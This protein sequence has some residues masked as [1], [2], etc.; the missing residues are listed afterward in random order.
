MIKGSGFAARIAP[1]AAGLV[2]LAVVA[3]LL[4]YGNHSAYHH[5][6]T[7]WGF[8]PFRYAFVDLDVS[9]LSAWDCARKG[10]EGAPPDY[11]DVIM[12]GYTYSPFW[13]TLDWIPLGPADRVWAGLTLG[14]AFLISLCALPPAV[15]LTEIVVRIA[16]AL[17][18]MVAF[19]IERANLD[20]LI[21]LLVLCALALLRRSAIARTLGYCVAV[22]AGAIKY[23][24]FVLLG[25]V[26]RER[27]RLAIPIALA[28]LIALS[29][30]YSI[31]SSKILGTAPYIAH[32]SPFGD[33]FGASN[34]PFGAFLLLRDLGT[35]PTAL[36]RTLIV[37]MALAGGALLLLV[38]RLIRPQNL[39]SALG[40]IDEERRLALLAGALL[41]VG[42]FFAGQNVGYRGI[43]LLLLIPGLSALARD[44]DAG[45]VA[46]TSR[47]AMVIV[48]ILMWSEAI[49]WWVHLVFTAGPVEGAP[50]TA[51]ILRQ[52]WDI[53]AWFAREAAWWVL[54]ILLMTIIIDGLVVHFLKH[55]REQPQVIQP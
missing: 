5:V 11:C 51:P 41:L 1:S 18:T 20:L 49:R 48:P 44:K 8:E 23:Y 31:Y 45:T 50:N 10:A 34:L 3:G 15:S 38:I 9:S 47:L 6:L 35:L 17:S 14:I 40:R 13:L 22:L 30:F 4:L 19:G 46:T 43:F 39:S 52:P 25:L 26:A 7:L 42:C 21:F 36:I 54:I 37:A 27:L 24:P 55:H 16:A 2:A 33:M 28:S 53:F 32:G 12:R 29:A